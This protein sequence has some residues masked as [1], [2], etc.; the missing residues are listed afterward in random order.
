MQVQSSLY[1]ARNVALH[2]VA[3][4]NEVRGLKILKIQA[5]IRCNE[6]TIVDGALKNPNRIRV[7]AFESKFQAFEKDSKHSNP[8]TNHSKGIRSSPLQIQT[9]PTSFKSFESKFESFE[10]DWN[11]SNEN[12]NHSKGIRIIRNQI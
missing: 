12:S 5:F 8:N 1:L 4:E 11:H 6:G 3:H 9:I 7:E 2:Q 10:R